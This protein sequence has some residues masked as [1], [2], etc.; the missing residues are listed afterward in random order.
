[1]AFRIIHALSVHRLTTGDI[2]A[3]FGATPEELRDTLCLYQPGIEELG[4]EPAEDLL[5]QV[6]T[7][8]REIHKT[9]SGQFISANP[10]NRQYYLDLKK[11]EDYDA[12]I[13]KRADS[14]EDEEL[15][16]Y[17]FE[18]LKRVME[19][20]DTTYVTGYK[21]WE[22]ELEWYKRKVARRGY[23]FFGS[24]N[25]RSTA[26]PPRDFYLY[27]I[28]PFDPPPFKDEK[29]PDEVFLR[30]TGTDDEF[31]KT[32]RL[33]AA[34]LDLVTTSSGHAKNV[35]ETK[36]GEFLRNL[37]KWLQENMTTAFD[38]THQGRKKSLTEWTK[39]R[40]IR[41]LT[42]LASH[43]R[44]NFKDL[45]NAVAGIC[46]ETWFDELSP[47]HP[48]FSLLVTS[49]S[50]PQ[51]AEDALRFIA[52][53]T[54]TK[55][56]TAVMDALELLDGERI[57]AKKSRYAQ[58]VL[59]HM[60]KKG[61]GQVANRTEIIKDV[62]GVEY[63]APETFRLEPEWV[64]VVLASLVYSGD[65]VLA[66][67]GKKFDATSLSMLSATPVYDL[68]N[69]KHIERPKEW[70]LPAI[71]ALFEL[72]GLP[73]GLANE[74]ILNKEEPV[75]GLQK[76]IHQSVNRL[77]M[78]QQH[79]NNRFLIWGSS[80]LTEH[81]TDKLTSLLEE[82]KTFLES[83]QAYSTP[84]KLKNFRFT[85][86]DVRSHQGGLDALK[87]LDSLKGLTDEVGPI[88][89]YL[90]TAEAVM[91]EDHPWVKKAGKVK[92]EV[93]DQ[94]T[95]PEKRK[96][97]DTRQQV[98]HKLLEAKKDFLKDYMSLHTRFRLGINDDK[99]KTQL[100]SDERLVHLQAL[101]AI[102]LMPSA[103][104]IDFRNRLADLT[105]C[106]QL[107]E[108]ELKDSPVCPHCSFKPATEKAKV[109]V[110]KIIQQ[111]DSELDGLISDWTQTL[112]SNLEDPTTRDDL[113][114]LKKEDRKLIEDFVKKR[115]L[116]EDLSHDFIQALKEVLSG[117]M[118]VEV[119]AEHLKAAL[120]KGGSPATPAEMK[121]RFEEF[122]AQLTKGKDLTKVRI[123][124]E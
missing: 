88:S 28:Q 60:K 2:H 63:M 17:Y 5:S 83:C 92:K 16:R 53:A 121:K 65:L 120:L 80:L 42:G 37:V 27:F 73:P 115:T 45:I 59:D 31:R 58:Y 21:I 66:I 15:D 56:A 117:L 51:A 61:Q 19:C 11:T 29:K 96:R 23:L 91:P 67:P 62:Y 9:V 72:M 44:I 116:P 4:G 75:Q 18:A 98:M 78:A 24:P 1:M 32:L 38:I 41:E 43:E 50:R 6:E 40:N 108:Q 107:T 52:G 106:Y 109:P 12:I 35:Y 114:L 55:Q 86:E 46:L 47:E 74:V 33:F 103:Q 20:S 30:L 26:V 112:L 77:V 118:K 84:G 104:L 13:E 22:H 3:S 36:A 54:R 100:M 85:E 124:L 99:R 39:G 122:L 93:L 68:A 95:D 89:S 123:V 82:T 119:K 94:I 111:M 79:V 81:E 102:P 14:L 70:N 90:S 69:F 10:E 87:E 110:A 113:G 105:P 49:A 97:P 48:H 71:K 101:S 8:L 57:D 76:A 34:A 7:V 25:E 64:V